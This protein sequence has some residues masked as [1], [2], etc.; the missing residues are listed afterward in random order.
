MNRWQEKSHK[1]T[2]ATVR[3]TVADHRILRLRQCL[4]GSQHLN[5]VSWQPR[6]LQFSCHC[7]EVIQT[8]AA[9]GQSSTA[10]RSSHC[11]VLSAHLSLTVAPKQHVLR[12]L[13]RARA[14]TCNGHLGAE[15][16]PGMTRLWSSAPPHLGGLPPRGG[17]CR[18]HLGL[19][20]KAS[21]ER[22]LA[23]GPVGK[24]AALAGADALLDGRS[25][26]PGIQKVAQTCVLVM[27]MK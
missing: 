13:P 20:E 14:S 23:G 9:C 24:A 15:K 6:W 10:A 22:N 3:K 12:W 1:S 4:M 16:P 18:G 11:H 5:S 21:G 2:S 27:T 25:W 26:R 7:N 19:V 8:A 17:G